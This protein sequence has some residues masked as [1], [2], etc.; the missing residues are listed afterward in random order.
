MAWNERLVVLA[1]VEL[2]GRR[3]RERA[4]NCENKKI[5]AH[6]RQDWLSTLSAIACAMAVRGGN[7][8]TCEATQSGFQFFAIAYP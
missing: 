2:D 6:P 8:K 7:L 3:T 4:C 1:R 5:L